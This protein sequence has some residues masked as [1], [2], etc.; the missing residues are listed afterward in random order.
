MPI[1]ADAIEWSRPMDP[2]DRQKRKI[3]LSGAQAVLGEM[4]QM[5]GHTLELTSEAWLMG[6]RISTAL[7][8]EPV[9]TPTSIM[10]WLEVVPEMRADPAFDAG[11]R[12]A[13]ELT[14]ETNE[15]PSP[16]YQK[17]FVQKVIQQ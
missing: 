9:V 2:T 11:V 3:L 12:L 7:G 15:V 10:I 4:A 17:T 6:L 14:I 16:R 13:M 8:Y 5:T 1:P